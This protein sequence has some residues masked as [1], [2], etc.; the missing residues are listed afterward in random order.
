MVKQSLFKYFSDITLIN[1]KYAVQ[2]KEIDEI[3]TQAR[4]SATATMFGGVS[5]LLGEHT[6]AGKTAGI[7]QATINTYQGVTEVWKAPSVL[8]EPF[9]TASKVLATATT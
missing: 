1:E 5:K 9:N 6:Q 2:Q 7:A 3:N 8:P 4:L